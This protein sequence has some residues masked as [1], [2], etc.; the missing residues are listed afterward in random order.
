MVKKIIGVL[1]E[2]IQQL[3]QSPIASQTNSY[4]CPILHSIVDQKVLYQIDK[5]EEYLKVQKIIEE[6]IFK[7]GKELGANVWP[8]YA[9]TDPWTIPYPDQQKMTFEEIVNFRRNF[10][11][12]ELKKYR[13]SLI[14]NTK[15][16][17]NNYHQLKRSKH[18]KN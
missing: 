15:I 9:P 18:D 3:Q 1:D 16:K 7:K 17:L 6:F 2:I 12:K 4:I 10:K 14:K 8:N 5:S 11:I 13:T